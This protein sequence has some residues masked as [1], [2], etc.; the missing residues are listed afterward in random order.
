MKS[1]AEHPATRTSESA[2]FVRSKLP[3]LFSTH[4]WR[5]LCTKSFREKYPIIKSSFLRIPH[6]LAAFVVR[7]LESGMR[8]FTIIQILKHKHII[9]L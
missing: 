6:L 2:I 8:G 3:P 1:C 7:L 5:K 4:F 9:H